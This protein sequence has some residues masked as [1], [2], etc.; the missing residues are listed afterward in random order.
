MIRITDE[1]RVT[2]VTDPVC[3][4]ELDLDD[5]KAHELHEGWMHFF[6]SAGCREKFRRSPD[7]YS[8]V[9]RQ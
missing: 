3:G 1:V 7:R 2:A 8:R 6:C 9:P 5:T 4:A